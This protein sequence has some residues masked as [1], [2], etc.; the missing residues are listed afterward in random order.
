[1]GVGN[2]RSLDLNRLS[3]MFYI[4]MIPVT[5]YLIYQIYS[6]YQT[7]KH[8]VYLYQFCELRR[9][10]LNLLWLEHD[11]LSREDYIALRRLIGALNMAISSY[12]HKTIMFNFRKFIRFLK[13]I[14]HLDKKVE[15]DVT[16]H[17]KI[18]ALIKK[19]EYSVLCSFLAF[20]PFIKSELLIKL[21]IR[22]LS[23]CVDRGGESLRG[24]LNAF[25]GALVIKQKVD[26]CNLR[27]A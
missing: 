25:E 27:F 2:Q 7:K 20:T 6:A 19:V 18:N 14:Q 8:D 5:L 10:A 15:A 23:V 17:E 11:T 16:E 3:N 13:S 12:S 26:N 24:L 22:F 1:M 9:Q 21:A 4:L